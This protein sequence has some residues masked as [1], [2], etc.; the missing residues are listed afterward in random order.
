MSAPVRFLAVAV[1]G[2]MAI[3]AGTLG[4]MPGFTISPA[5]AAPPPIVPTEFSP[6]AATTWPSEQG[7]AQQPAE[8]LYPQQL[9]FQPVRVPIPYYLPATSSPSPPQLAA[10]APRPAW[11][12]ESLGYSL[13]SL[14][15]APAAA[16]SVPAAPSATPAVRKLDRWQLSTWALLRGTPTPGT[17]ASGGTLGGSQAGARLLYLFNRSLAASVRTTSPVGGS[18]G[19]ELAGGIRWTPL[20]SV[21][22]ALTVERRQS[23]SRWGGGRSDFAMFVEGGLYRRPMPWRFELDAYLQAGMVGADERDLFADG[24]LAFTRPVLGKVSAGF[25]AWGGYQPGIYR[26]DAGPRVSIKVRDN[27]RAHVDYRQRIAG[28]AQPAS[29]A[30]LTLAADF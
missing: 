12:L 22:V 20:Q 30:T 23:I 9:Q 21:P 7:Y 10:L 28:D 3:R 14:P 24:A 16:Q 25:G 13:P 6:F 8:S 1:F 18:R 15:A 2:W 4:A 27:V 17:L 5:Q 29:G 19:A 26:V 11:S